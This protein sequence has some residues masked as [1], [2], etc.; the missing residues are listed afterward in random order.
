[1]MR[2][3]SN[4]A[5]IWIAGSAVLAVSLAVALGLLTAPSTTAEVG[6]K[7]RSS[8]EPPPNVLI[9]TIDTLRADRLSSYGYDRP[10]SPAIDRLLARGA[11]FTQAR[12]VQPLTNPALSS[13]ITSRYPHEHGGTRNG[14]RMRRGLSSLP[15]LLADQGGYLTAAFVGNWTLR[16]RV[17]GLGEHFQVYREVLSKKRWF[18]LFRGEADGRDLTDAALEWLAAHGAKRRP[19]LL[20]VHYVEPHAPYVFHEQ[21]A[22]RLGLGDDPDKSDRYDTEIAFAD[23]QVGRLVAAL[24]AQPGLARRTLVIFAA[25]HGESLGEH[26][27]W[28]HG[29]NLYEPGLHIPF[30]MVWPGHIPPQVLDAPAL[31]VDVAPTVLGMMGLRAPEAF[32]GQDWS[33]VFAG[34]RPAPTERTTWFQ[35]HRGAVL[36]A[37][38][39]KNARSNGLLEVGLVA[40][41]LK[42]ILDVDSSEM[43]V[44]D[45]RRDPGETAPLAD[46]IE[47]P[48]GLLAWHET[49]TT[50]LE[51]SGNLPP[52]ALGQ[53]DVER[54]RALGY[55]D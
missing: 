11:R 38:D 39:A 14:L 30:G 53:E 42:E 19:F 55:T 44:Y 2:R 49:V 10:T 29:R 7:A 25:D 52:P 50:G 6:R 28:G 5:R 37:E 24:E 21:Y 47:P 20:W 54:L 23:E 33:G 41:G 8:K 1:M 22:E 32:H 27:Y 43:R 15:K 31:L 17:S 18:G 36:T 48:D 4:E 3:S 13:M 40:R 16:D 26:D 12:T 34:S 35:A 45:L 9:V 46:G 51:S